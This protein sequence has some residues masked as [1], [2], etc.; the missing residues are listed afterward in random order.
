MHYNDAWHVQNLLR[1]N[2][3]ETNFDQLVQFFLYSV[4]LFASHT[5]FVSKFSTKTPNK[6]FFN[7]FR[8]WIT[9]SINP[10]TF[11]PPKNCSPSSRETANRRTEQNDTNETLNL[12]KARLSPHFHSNIS[13]AFPCSLFHS[14]WTAL[15]KW[16]NKIR[17][18]AVTAASAVLRWVNN[19][20]QRTLWLGGEVRGLS[21]YFNV[22]RCTS[23]PIHH[24]GFLR[25]VKTWTTRTCEWRRFFWLCYPGKKSNNM[26]I[27]FETHSVC[28]SHYMDFFSTKVP[29]IIALSQSVPSWC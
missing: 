8:C 13:I 20:T 3:Q 21:N 24:R 19:G 2:P 14:R 29:Q 16:Q 1:S 4:N 6:A 5:V 18:P 28:F 17:F 27:E 10:K 25:P 22:N 15:W 11:H 9:T 12:E 23:L 26:Q 7:W